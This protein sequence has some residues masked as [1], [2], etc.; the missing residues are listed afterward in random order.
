MFKLDLNPRR[1]SKGV[2]GALLEIWRWSKAR[3]AKATT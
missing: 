1:V 3:G 2:T